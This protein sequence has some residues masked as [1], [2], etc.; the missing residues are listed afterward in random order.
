MKTMPVCAGCTN[1]IDALTLAV[2]GEN[3][4]YCKQCR[5]VFTER[6]E[7]I[8]DGERLWEENRLGERCNERLWWHGHQEE[9]CDRGLIRRNP[10]SRKK[11]NPL[12]RTLCWL[13]QRVYGQALLD[14]SFQH[15]SGAWIF[16]EDHDIWFSDCTMCLDKMAYST[17]GC[18]AC[19]IRFEQW[20][21]EHDQEH[22]R[23]SIRVVRK[24]KALVSAVYLFSDGQRR[25]MRL[26]DWEP[27]GEV[28]H[29][30]HKGKSMQ[31]NHA[32]AEAY[33]LEKQGAAIKHFWS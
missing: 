3:Q 25:G 29:S 6:S 24:K 11:E 8:P 16:G 33:I 19:A 26:Y 22:L 21:Q 32:D 10:R 20:V 9:D 27:E 18:G 2:E 12:K 31:E 5:Y 17:P 7:P 15:P 4:R 30:F 14:H 13:C 28:E 1:P 23:Y